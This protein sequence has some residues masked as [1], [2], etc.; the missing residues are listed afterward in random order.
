MIHRP[1]KPHI[2]PLPG[3]GD[4]RWQSSKASVEEHG[5]PSVML[6]D[7]DSLRTVV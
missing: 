6:G 4:E 1:L 2:L 3:C 5:F 7:L